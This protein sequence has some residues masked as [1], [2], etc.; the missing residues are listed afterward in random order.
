MTRNDFQDDG[1]NTP[2][3]IAPLP[4]PLVKRP[5]GLDP[6]EARAMLA[7]A[8]LGMELGEYDRRIIAWLSGWDQPTTAAIASIIY[9]AR[10]EGTR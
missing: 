10:Q 2:A 3:L 4:G 6:A 1:D 7:A 5:K 8:V 9:R